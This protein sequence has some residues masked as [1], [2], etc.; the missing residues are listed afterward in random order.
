MPPISHSNP[1][2]KRA[3][4]PAFDWFTAHGRDF[5]WGPGRPAITTRSGEWWANGHDRSWR[6]VHCIGNAD[7]LEIQ[8]FL[9][10]TPKSGEI[11]GNVPD[12][13]WGLPTP[14]W[15][16]PPPHPSPWGPI[17]TYDLWF[18]VG[19]PTHPHGRRPQTSKITSAGAEVGRGKGERLGIFKIL[20]EFPMSK[21]NHRCWFEV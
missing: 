11:K 19:P 12:V 21:S 7:D 1:F 17:G 6:M 8:N 16:T 20:K 18:G 15:S 13:L 14:A 10:L 3:G 2:T 9:R 4:P 5:G